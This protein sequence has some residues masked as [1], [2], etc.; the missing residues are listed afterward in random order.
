MGEEKISYISKEML[1][2]KMFFFDFFS[3]S[4]ILNN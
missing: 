4:N 3:S 1:C 2:K